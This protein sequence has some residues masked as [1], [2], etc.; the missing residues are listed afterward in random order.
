MVRKSGKPVAVDSHLRHV[1][2]R[3]VEYAFLAFITITASISLL[4][5]LGNQRLWQDEAQTALISKTVLT[6]GIPLGYDGRNFFSQEEGA[7]YGRNHVWR[8]HTW[9]QFYAVAASFKTL[10]V[11]TFT[12]RLPFALLGAATIVLIYFVSKKMW[13]SQRAGMI[14]ALILLFSIPFLLLSRQCRYYSMSAFFSLLGLYAYLGILN[15]RKYSLIIFTLAATLLFN[16]HYVYTAALLAAACSHALLFRRDRV[17]VVLAASTVVALL[18]APWIVWLSGASYPSTYSNSFSAIRFAKFAGAYLIQIFQYTFSPLLLLPIAVIVIGKR[19][20]SREQ[21]KKSKR[22]SGPQ[23]SGMKRAWEFV[24]GSEERQNIALL[25]LF[26]AANL[27]IVL[28]APYPFFRYLA[29]VI[30]AFCLIIALIIESSLKTHLLLGAVASALFI[31]QQPVLDYIYETTHDYDGP[32]EGIVEYLNA[33]GKEGDTVLIT[34]EDLPVKF[35]TNLRVLGGL[36]GEDLSDARKADWLIIRKYT[37]SRYQETVRKFISENL[38]P[39]KF[40]RI[41]IPYPDIPF[42]NRE[43]PSEHR[44]RTAT[45]ES[46]VVIYRRIKE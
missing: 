26:I 40:E 24:S 23:M 30:P 17:K 33:H 39:D 25:L 32:V 42:E 35:Y 18:A 3:V 8:W 9:L 38:A 29:P 6:G 45:D 12:A 2:G 10:G 37:V 1:Q 36:T 20:K 46:Q 16:T 44:Y 19:K 14:A 22:K 41:E 28:P 5:N 7:E 21:E 34:Y 27:A 43:S 31:F 4:A 11:N 13:E 15:R